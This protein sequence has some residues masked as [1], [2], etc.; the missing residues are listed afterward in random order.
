MSRKKGHKLNGS[1]AP[2]LSHTRKSPAWQMLSV[3]PRALFMELQASYF[4]DIEGY[5]FLS[6]REGAGLLRTRKNNI[7]VWFS[8]L[9]H[10]GFLV[11]VRD[12][13]QTGLGEGECARYR[14]T[15]RYFHG[16]P[17][18]RDFEKWD[19]TVFEPPIRARSENEKARL[20]GLRKN[21]PPVP[22]PDTPR[23][24]VGDVRAGSETPEI[25][26]RRTTV[27][28]ISGLRKRTTV[29][30]VSRFTTPLLPWSPPTLT[31]VTD[32][33]QVAAVREQI[34]LQDLR[35]EKFGLNGAA[36]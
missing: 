21:R 9:E 7:S 27:G 17:P 35:L 18:T 4:T 1:F 25:G 10:Y 36:A 5:V 19:G 24:M 8:A 16:Q 2:L 28:D 23:T 11:K 6:C 33:G 14:L 30:D 31:E 12:A 22:R 29:G 32:E 3:G 15:D 34:R 26:N 20:N 13:H